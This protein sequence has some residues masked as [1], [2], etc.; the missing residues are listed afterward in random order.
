MQYSLKVNETE[1][2]KEGLLTFEGDMTIIHA[3]KIKK[4]LLE[5]FATVDL[6][7]LNIKTIE[8]AD[9]SFVQLICASHREAFLTGK[10]IIFQGSI[11]AP[12]M[13]K[14]PVC[15]SHYVN[16]RRGRHFFLN[17]LPETTVKEDCKY[18]KDDFD[19]G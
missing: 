19:R 3:R 5:A 16:N 9:I 7:G 8:S 14:K 13:L 15:G 18:G 11:V 2:G 12:Q 6:L 17:N 10:K 4:A 1:T